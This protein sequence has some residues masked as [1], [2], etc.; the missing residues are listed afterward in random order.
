MMNYNFDFCYITFCHKI[1]PFHTSHTIAILLNCGIY[2]IKIGKLASYPWFLMNN[3]KSYDPLNN[4]SSKLAKKKRS[5]GQKRVPNYSRE[6]WSRS[7]LST[8]WPINLSIYLIL[9]Y[10]RT[11]QQPQSCTKYT[12]Q[13]TW[14]EQVQQHNESLWWLRKYIPHLNRP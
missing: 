6:P 1:P 12:S 14:A 5:Y 9:V 2:K 8:I 10:P 13:E 11:S 7:F 3:L 4:I